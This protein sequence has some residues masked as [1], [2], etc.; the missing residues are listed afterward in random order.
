M[1]KNKNI[2]VSIVIPVYNRK[3]RLREI[4]PSL[5]N[6][7]FLGSYEIL[8][9]DDGS[10]DGSC[11]E[12]NEKYVRVIKQANQGAAC[13]RHKGAVEAYGNI[14][15]FHDSDD[16]ATEDKV[17][18]LFKALNDH[19]NYKLAFAI[20]H[21]NKNN[22]QLPNWAKTEN[23][24]V[25]FD[26]PLE[27]YFNH[28]FP[29]ASAMNLA[30]RKEDAIIASSESAFYKAANDYQLQFKAAFLGSIVAVP[31][32]TNY[33]YIGPE[34]SISSKFGSYRQAMF[35]LFSL[36]E[37]F[38]T[39]ANSNPIYLPALK[40]RV[41]N[42]GPNALLYLFKNKSFAIYFWPLLKITFK[43]GRLMKLSKQFY[44]AWLRLKK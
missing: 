7:T 3:K 10:T 21:E 22:W 16:T 6:Q 35:A 5:Q 2:D 15:I 13:A 42:E 18:L 19:K 24:Y 1:T 40:Q 4:L 12:L 41:E 23:E 32:I 27:H 36:I 29:L 43:Y 34:E 17:A 33:Y 11:D 44:W 25:Y 14:V 8:L 30:M 31:K 37:N 20:T 9:I 38:T 28:S 26:Q 39:Q